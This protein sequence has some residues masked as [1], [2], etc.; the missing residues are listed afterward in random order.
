GR[1][2]FSA[3]DGAHGV[4][5]WSSNGTTVATVLIRDIAQ[6]PGSPDSRPAGLT[7][8]GSTLFFAAFQ[9]G[10]GFE[11]WKSN[12]S[13]SGTLQVKNIR[14]GLAGS[15]IGNAYTAA[16]GLLF[17]LADDGDH[18]TELWRS[19]GTVAGTFMLR[20]INPGPDY[21]VIYQLVV[22]GNIVYF[23]A[24][25]GIGYGL[26][27]SDGSVAGTHRLTPI[28]GTPAGYTLTGSGALFYFTDTDFTQL[29]RSDGTEVGTFV[30]QTSEFVTSLTDVD[31]RL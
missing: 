13:A 16:G 27:T 9:T 5:L 4:E 22:R 15:T 11:L 20:D 21:P 6:P 28:P 23:I 18:G 14:P 7:A 25:D 30:I 1:A 24:T 17:F 31:G 2:F 8:V 29:W 3:D 26:W 10:Q 12:G 19:D